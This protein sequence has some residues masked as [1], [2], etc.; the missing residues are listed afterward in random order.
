MKHLITLF[1]LLFA[2]V[3]YYIGSTIS[4]TGL[5]ILAVV[6]EGMIFFGVFDPKKEQ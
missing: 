1:F 5:V 4:A 3:F 6:F 2:S